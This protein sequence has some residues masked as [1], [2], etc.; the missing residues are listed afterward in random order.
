MCLRNA[1]AAASWISSRWAPDE[2]IV[3]VVAAGER[4]R[5]G[6]LRPAVEDLWGAGAFISH[7]TGAGWTALSPE[8]AS[9]RAAWLAVRRDA[10]GALLSCASGRE[11]V[12]KGY[13]ADVEI[14]AEVD[15]SR[16]VPLLH[17]HV[18]RP[19]AGTGRISSSGS[20]PRC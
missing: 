19:A 17:E 4:W 11:L 2:A 7:L 3:A 18:F 14:A 1:A 12:A 9:G 16:A 6:G 5:T 20:S 15:V 10:L 8:A 13:R